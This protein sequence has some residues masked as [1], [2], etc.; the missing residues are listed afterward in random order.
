MSVGA[1]RR[2]FV[3]AAIAAVLALSLP[4]GNPIAA[5]VRA[6]GPVYP[7][8]T[9]TIQFEGPPSIDISA[10]AGV[11]DLTTGATAPTPA[12]VIGQAGPGPIQSAAILRADLTKSPL[13]STSLV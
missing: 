2:S 7:Q 1:F 10:N 3:L 6:T 9:N 5:P 4:A 12:S 13:A 11:V 8:V